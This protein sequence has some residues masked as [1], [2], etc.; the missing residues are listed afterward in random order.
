MGDWYKENIE[1]EIRDIVRLLRDNGINTE[2]SCGH[3][4]YIQCQYVND[5]EIDKVKILLLENEHFDFTIIIGICFMSGVN[6]SS[7]YTIYLPQPGQTLVEDG[8]I[9]LKSKKENKK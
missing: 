9:I 2:C 1:E 6:L 8:Y 3:D 7:H 4:M 5:E